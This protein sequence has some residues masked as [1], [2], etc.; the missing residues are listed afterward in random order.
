MTRPRFAPTAEAS[1]WSRRWVVPLV[2][3]L[4]LATTATLSVAVQVRPASGDT[5]SS[6]QQ[7][8]ASLAQQLVREQLQVEAARQQYSVLTAGAASAASAVAAVQSQIATDQSR[9]TAASAA[10]RHQALIEYM[11]A[12]TVATGSDA[13]L[14]AGNTTAQQDRSE[15]QA[16]AAGS[17]TTAVDRLRVAQGALTANQAALR[18]NELR[19]EQAVS[20]EA[21]VLAQVTADAQQLAAAQA[22]VTGQL[23]VAVA[24]QAAAQRA[25]AAA[26]IRAAEMAAVHADPAPATVTAPP[27]QTAA[28]NPGTPPASTLSTSGSGGAVTDP[29]LNPF[30]QCVVQAESGGNYG[31]VSPNGIYRGAF[32]FSQATWNAAA[33]AAGLPGLV[34]VPPNLASKAD[35]DTLAVALYAMDGEQPWVDSCRN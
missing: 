30:L 35:Q 32:Q 25:A 22:Q 16:V 26:A 17:I 19:A 10:V 31:A 20:D 8:A 24:Q 15:Y 3:V 27:A 9:L 1:A 12:G 11:D 21:T 4:A 33:L 34:G 13:L 2:L 7:Q 29:A 23:A 18:R 14:F 6:L 5:V 28:G